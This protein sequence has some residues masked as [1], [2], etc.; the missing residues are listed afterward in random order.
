MKWFVANKPRSLDQAGIA[1]IMVTLVLMAVM[2]LIVLGF[3]EIARHDQRQALDRQLSSQAFYAAET[4]VNDYAQKIRGFFEANPAA[5]TTEIQN[6]VSQSSCTPS[7]NSIY[8]GMSNVLNAANNVQYTCVLVN[9]TP[10]SLQYGSVGNASQVIP[11]NSADGSSLDHMVISWQPTTNQVKPTQGCPSNP[12]V[13]T[14]PAAGSWSSGGCKLGIVRV[15]LVPAPS[16]A[17]PF[18][19]QD[20]QA[21]TMTVFLVPTVATNTGTGTVSYTQSSNNQYLTKV[22]QGTV[23]AAKCDDSS[24]CTV[25]VTGLSSAHYYLRANSIYAPV[26]LTVQGYTTP[27]GSGG[28]PVKLTDAQVLVDST[29]LA[30]D[31]LRRIQVRISVNSSSGGSVFD[32]A[33]ESTKSLC[34]QFKTAPSASGSDYYA[35]TATCP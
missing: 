22:N 28:P 18:S 33:L 35:G 7:N 24:G 15:D 23:V 2:T 1:S 4:G 14:F 13:D 16:S 26:A 27:I 29:G 6:K 34:E 8:A 25:T 32:A 5:S 20:L 21:N 19:L 31:V 3:A 12:N 11:V 17:N 30:Q 10:D 9:A